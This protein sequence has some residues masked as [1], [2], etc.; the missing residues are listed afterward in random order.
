MK[1]GKPY[2]RAE[3]GYNPRCGGR[4]P[5]D[6]DF[7]AVCD[8]DSCQVKGW[9]GGGFTSGF[10]RRFGCNLWAFYFARIGSNLHVHTQL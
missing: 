1:P 4:P 3:P 8:A 5:L 7:V 2:I 6:V 10:T 9:P